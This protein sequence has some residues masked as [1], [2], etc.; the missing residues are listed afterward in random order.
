MPYFISIFNIYDDPMN[1]CN[2]TTQLSRAR[3]END[4][5]YKLIDSSDISVIER[6][7]SMISV[8]GENLSC[9]LKLKKF[10][11]KNV[12]DHIPKLMMIKHKYREEIFNLLSSISA[13]YFRIEQTKVL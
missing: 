11:D 13:K 9:Y 1:Q 8:H 10:S 2:V 12:E 6:I 5:I 3:N 7:V 4:A